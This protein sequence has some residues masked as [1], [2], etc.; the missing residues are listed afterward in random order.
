MT[1]LSLPWRLFYAACFLAIVGL[2]VSLDLR[3]YNRVSALE[4][5]VEE[6]SAA[7]TAYEDRIAQLEASEAT[8]DVDAVVVRLDALESRLAALGDL[9]LS[10]IELDRAKEPLLNR[11]LAGIWATLCSTREAYAWIEG[12]NPGGCDEYRVAQ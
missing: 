2:A 7:A 1:S 6:A 4:D 12:R 10:T 5:R 8:T 11:E 9:V 3:T